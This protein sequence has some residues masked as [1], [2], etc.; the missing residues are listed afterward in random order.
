MDIEQ[1]YSVLI[2][3]DEEPAR[4]L[5]VDYLLTRPE[6]KLSGIAR[7]G[8]DAFQK[9][10]RQEY[11]LV[12]M[13]IHLPRMTGIE[14][15][16]RLKKIPYVIFTTAYEQYAI[17]AFNIGAV[18]YLLKPF[19]TE[20]F[21]Q[22]IEK[23]LSLHN[24]ETCPAISTTATGFAVKEQNRHYILPYQDIL[25]VSSHG[26][27]SIIH[28]ITEDIESAVILKD[29]ER[30]VPV[31]IFIRIHKQ[32]IV[33]I[34]YIAALEYYIGGQYIVY[35]N[36]ADDSPLPVGKKYASNLKSRLNMN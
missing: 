18:D 33:N 16:E 22:S 34:R 28:T 23:F 2:A 7:N 8:E 1:I 31:G 11:D 12:L 10:S 36:D 27:K 30:R 21:N 32:H 24:T 35:L 17:R 14:V 19:N 25:Y 3:E 13:D 6:L 26:K 4:E 20:R 5:L 15:L 9:L 29:F